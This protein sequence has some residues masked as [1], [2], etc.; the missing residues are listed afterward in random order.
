MEQQTFTTEDIRKLLFGFVE[1]FS[2]D[3]G[4]DSETWSTDVQAPSTPPDEDPVKQENAP[5]GT[6]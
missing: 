5:K 6:L 1:G 3:S 2:S 4:S